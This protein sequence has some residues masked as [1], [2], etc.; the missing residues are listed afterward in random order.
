MSRVVADQ[1]IAL[2]FERSFQRR[3]RTFCPTGLAITVKIVTGM[4]PVLHHITL[5][6][7]ADVEVATVF[8][9][10]VLAEATRTSRRSH[11]RQSPVTKNSTAIGESA[12]IAIERGT[13][14]ES[15][16][17]FVKGVDNGNSTENERRNDVSGT[18]ADQTWND[19]LAATQ[20]PSVDATTP[21]GTHDR[22]GRDGINACHLMSGGRVL[23]QG[24]EDGTLNRLIPKL[25][26]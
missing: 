1:H 13:A 5:I 26:C 19:V 7:H 9:R 20:T 18:C 16:N 3:F 24:Q 15:E 8:P 21:D 17:A 22:R 12:K 2:V 25:G 14:N 23:S 6:P 4:H 10:L 11:L